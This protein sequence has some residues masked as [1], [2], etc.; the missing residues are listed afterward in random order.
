MGLSSRVV[1][2]VAVA[3]AWACALGCSGDVAHLSLP[4]LDGA[5]RSWVIV[6]HAESPELYAAD[7]TSPLRLPLPAEPLHLE[8]VAY[9]ETLA[10]LGWSVGPLVPAPPGARSTS[11]PTALESFEADVEDGEP[12]AWRSSMPSAAVR[13]FRLIAPSPCLEMFPEVGELPTRGDIVWAVSLDDETALM[14]GDSTF[15]ILFRAGIGP[16]RV[17]LVV[18]PG[19]PLGPTDTPTPR[20]G[21][22]DAR[23]RLWLGD[24]DGGL[25]RGAIGTSS[26][27]VTRVVGPHPHG[28]VR[29]VD[30][31]PDDPEGQL[32]VMT[33]SGA[34]AR[35]DGDRW[36]ELDRIG[37]TA[38]EENNNTLVWMGR[39]EVFAGTSDWPAIRVIR[40]QTREDVRIDGAEG[41]AITGMTKLGPR[42]VMVGLSTGLVAHFVDERWTALGRASLV[43]DLLTF[44]RWPHGGFLYT[45]AFGY[46][47]EWHPD[48]GFCEPSTGPIAP[49]SAKYLLPMGDALLMTGDE[50][51]IDGPTAWTLIRPR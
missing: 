34:V 17:P 27:T 48:A 6:R 2:R 43:L 42:E 36:V 18:A 13:D 40:G 23:R 25:W 19:S 29:T 49:A 50:E 11:L 28:R 30:G 38:R 8:L 24:R 9:R 46:L 12:G 35:L 1:R 7:A 3:W 39:D 37:M 51:R 26:I 14:G 20:G 10:E 21:F 4:P 44:Y 41:M 5:A 16:G 32:F 47:A 33:A 15:A 22:L 31:D 45:S